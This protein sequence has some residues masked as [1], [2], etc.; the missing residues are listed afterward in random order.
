MF[1]LKAVI[2]VHNVVDV[3]VFYPKPK[4]DSSIFQWLH[5]STLGEQKNIHGMLQA[6]QLLKK[7]FKN[8]WRLKLVGPL[9]KQ[10]NQLVIDLNLAE[11][12]T[13]TGELQ[14]NDVATAMQ[15]ADAFVLFSKHENFPCVIPEALCCGLPV[16]GSNVGGVA[17]AITKENGI[18]VNSD[19]IEMLANALAEIMNKRTNLSSENIAK[20]AQ[21]KY[22]NAVIGNQF[23]Q[24]YKKMI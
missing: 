6:F 14:H 3:N 5:V 15:N 16:V 10:Y 11:Q 21:N 13:F 8:N 12:I 24:L 4:E 1:Q 2:P 22:S 17:E 19:D 18:V 20:D 7:K 9:Y 23:V